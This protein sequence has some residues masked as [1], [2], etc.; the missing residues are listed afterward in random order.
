VVFQKGR[1][2][3]SPNFRLSS[4]QGQGRIGI[5][6]SKKIGCHAR[7]NWVKRRIRESIFNLE[8]N[9]RP[10]LDYIVIATPNVVAL[11]FEA[12][13]EELRDALTRMNQRWAAD[14]E[15]S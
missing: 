12:V 8:S 3:S 14:L 15:S 13:R 5:A 9:L 2:V 4:D 11:E 6:T 10:D 7:R 1:R